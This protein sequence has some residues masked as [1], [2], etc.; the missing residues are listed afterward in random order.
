MVVLRGI[1][2]GCRSLKVSPALPLRHSVSYCLRFHVSLPPLATSTVAHVVSALDIEP[3]TEPGPLA[4][5]T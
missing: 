3:E 2:M 1:L 5:S 4:T